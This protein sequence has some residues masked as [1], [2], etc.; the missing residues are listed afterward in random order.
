MRKQQTRKPQF[1]NVRIEVPVKFNSRLPEEVVNDLLDVLTSPVIEK[2]T[3]NVFAFR[4]V[5][6]ND[7]SIKGNVIVGNVVRYDAV[8]GVLIVDIY[9]RFA[10][11]IDQISD[12]IAFVLTS[13]DQDT[14]ANKINRIIIEEDKNK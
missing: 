2:I 12:R 1:K 14:K 9:E 10:E 11:V 7:P 13:F 4:S 3:L 8:N 5:I 6:N